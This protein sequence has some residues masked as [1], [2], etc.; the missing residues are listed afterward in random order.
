MS[1][2]AQ[3][4]DAI[5]AQHGSRLTLDQLRV[6]AVMHELNANC[7][8]VSDAARRLDIPRQCIWQ[9]EYTPDR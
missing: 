4:L 5:Y 3:H 6:T 8:D 9:G 1:G 7:F 2:E